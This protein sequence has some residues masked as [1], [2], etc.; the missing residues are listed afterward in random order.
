MPC[1]I[2]CLSE[3]VLVNFYGHFQDIKEMK[4]LR[5]LLLGSSIHQL[6]LNYPNLINMPNSFEKRL[7]PPTETPESQKYVQTVWFTFRLTWHLDTLDTY[8]TLQSIMNGKLSKQRFF[9]FP[10]PHQDYSN[11]ISW[12]KRDD[13][14]T[15]AI[16]LG[17]TLMFTQIL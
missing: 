12:H 17:N 14:V 3:L 7:T 16:A 2:P 6:L 13:I 15:V 1:W 8:T 4:L 5:S 11:H 9:L 10:Q